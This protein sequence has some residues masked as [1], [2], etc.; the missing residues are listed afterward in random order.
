MKRNCTN[1]SFNHVTD[2][3]CH[4]CHAM[5]HKEIDCRKP[6]YDNDRRNSRMFGNTNPIDRR[7]SNERTSRERKPFD[8]RKQ[9]ICYKCNNF[10]HIYQNFQP[11][12]DQ[13]NPRRRSP[14]CQLCN[15]FRHIEK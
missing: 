10:G 15:N 8:E 6:K 13:Q 1:K 9:I 3:Y 5:G 14:V 4:N 11:P 12:I 2:F 7:R